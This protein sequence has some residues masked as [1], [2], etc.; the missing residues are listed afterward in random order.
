MTWMTTERVTITNSPP[1]IG[2]SSCVLVAR[3]SAPSPAPIASAP[4]SPMNTRAGA[5]FH[6]RNP[7]HAPAIAAA[8]SARSRAGPTP[9]TW[10]WRNSQNPMNTKAAKAKV[11]DPAARPSRPSVRFTAFEVATITTT[12]HRMYAPTVRCTL[13]ERVNESSTS[14]FA[15]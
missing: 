2:R 15:R 11:P 14:T 3:A 13:M 6:Q 12:A 5:A 4:V 9:Y 1:T 8:T 10:G 7:V